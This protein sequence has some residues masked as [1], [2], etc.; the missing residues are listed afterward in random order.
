MSVFD[1]FERARRAKVRRH[2]E[3]V[4]NDRELADLGLSRAD[5]AVL[6]QG[7]PGTR[8]RMEH[9]GLCF[10]VSAAMI[11]ADRGTVLEIA[12]TCARCLEKLACQRAIEGKASFAAERCANRTRY[13]ALAAH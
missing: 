6:M 2:Q 5:Y 11:D 1:L 10:G 3:T 12:E 7:P 13:E 8:D 9:L 4:P